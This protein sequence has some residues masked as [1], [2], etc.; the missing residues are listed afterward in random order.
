MN[1]FEQ[2]LIDNPN[3]PISVLQALD[4]WSMDIKATRTDISEAALR[5]IANNPY[6]K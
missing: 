1:E 4:N 6:W 5:A 2:S 3:T